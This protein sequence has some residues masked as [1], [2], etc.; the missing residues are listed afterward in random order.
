M[1]YGNVAHVNSDIYYPRIP[2]DQFDDRLYFSSLCKNIGY[3]T[4]SNVKI[5]LELSDLNNTPI[6]QDTSINYSSLNPGASFSY[7]T[8]ND[9]LYLTEGLYNTKFM[10]TA[11]E[12]QDGDQFENNSI[13]SKFAISDDLFSIDGIDIYDQALTLPIGTNSFIDAEDESYIMSQYTL[14]KDTTNVVYGLEVLLSPNSIAGGSI[15]GHIFYSDD[16]LDEVISNPL[17]STE[18]I[19]ISQDHIN[20]GWLR[21]Y[22]DTVDSLDANNYM[23][24]IEMYSND[25]S[26][27]IAVLNDVTYVQDSEASV[28]IIDGQLN[29]SPNAAAIRLLMSPEN[30]TSI[31]KFEDDFLLF[32]NQ[33][34]PA[35]Q[36]TQINFSLYESQK[37]YFTV[38][39]AF[40]RIVHAEDLGN[41][42]KGKHEL[43]LDLNDFSPGIYFYS[44][45]TRLTKRSKQML[46]VK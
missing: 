35:S 31:E 28:M 36:S 15:I 7:N 34:N 9:T 42:A 44:I 40:G 8:N 37:V 21:V 38:V 33:P 22:F 29:T 32:Q 6:Y 10:V 45:Q 24:G 23:A 39:D 3:D 43:N 25:N 4:L 13:E 14:I 18:E 16:V 41:L 27:T 26:N 17:L 11:D 30:S 19:I 1:K 2:S 20:N 46:I 5:S 12:E